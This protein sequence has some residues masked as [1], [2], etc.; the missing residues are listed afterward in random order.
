MGHLF[1]VLILVL[2]ACTTARDVEAELAGAQTA[3]AKGRIVYE[4]SCSRCH[5]LY[6]PASYTTNE[7]RF[8]VRKYGRRA[9]LDKDR[10]ALVFTYLRA[11]C[12]PD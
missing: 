11:H 9:R 10:R 12:R 5:A 3:E 7:W 6:M 4:T 1:L 2:G 8:Y